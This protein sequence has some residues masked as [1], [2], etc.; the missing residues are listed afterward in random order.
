MIAEKQM[1]SKT[2]SLGGPGKQGSAD[3]GAF[4]VYS[5]TLVGAERHDVARPMTLLMY[6]SEVEE[7][8]HT[9]FGA[10]NKSLD[11]Q[12]HKVFNM[13]CALVRTSRLIIT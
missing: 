2:R 6:L 3:F 7:G 11:Q 8:G 1:V 12:M 4:V 10:K 5:W 9:V 13:F